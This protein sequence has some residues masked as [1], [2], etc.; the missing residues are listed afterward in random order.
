MFPPPLRGL[1][2]EAK[3]AQGS[4]KLHPGL[5]LLRPLQGYTT[6][7]PFLIRQRK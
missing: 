6:V 5:Q 1:G 7:I 2:P 4:A 3:W